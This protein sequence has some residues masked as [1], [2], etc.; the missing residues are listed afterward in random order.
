MH[1]VQA[2]P[3][4]QRRIEHSRLY[5]TQGD[6]TSFFRL[7][8]GRNLA[9]EIMTSD[10]DLRQGKP[11]LLALAGDR[12]LQP[13]LLDVACMQ[14][15]ARQQLLTVLQGNQLKIGYGLQE[16][17]VHLQQ[18]GLSVDGPFF[19]LRL[20][21]Q[22]LKAGISNK[23]P[24]LTTLIETLLGY[25]VDE[26][27]LNL[28]WEGRLY[29]GHLYAI[30]QKTKALMPLYAK[31]YKLLKNSRLLEAAELEFA[32]LPAVIE[33]SATGMPVNIEGLRSVQDQ[34]LN[35]A[36]DC[37]ERLKSWLPETVNLNS[38]QQVKAA[39]AEQGIDIPSVSKEDLM[40]LRGHPELV[41]SLLGYRKATSNESVYVRKCLEVV[42]PQTSR[43]YARWNQLGAMTG[44]F[45]CSAPPLQ[46]VP[47]N[48]GIRACFVQELG[49]VFVI[50]DLSQI[51]LRIAAELSGDSVMIAAFQN[52][53][54]LHTLTASLVTGKSIQD[55]T[56]DERQSA[57]ALNF[58][59]L[60]GMGTEGLQK[61][62]RVKYGVEMTA[63]EAVRFRESFFDAYQELAEWVDAQSSFSGRETRTLSGR[64]RRWN[65]E[66]VAATEL[67]NA[68]IQGTAA[69]ILKKALA[70]LPG[71]LSLYSAKIL[72]CIHDEI[73]LEVNKEQARE[74]AEILEVIMTEAGDYFLSHVPT[75]ADV[76]IAERWG[77]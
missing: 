46:G 62:A 35:Q 50:G 66:S 61:Y 28:P 63:A 36:R 54:D 72:A 30:H 23:P 77:K 8:A 44:R 34:L 65:T 57:K 4:T 27:D 18:A 64:R 73:I 52:D 10:S 17:G 3:L 42:D 25:E 21:A 47:K 32:C 74:V 24:E 49:K 20:A 41:S 59:L 40:S 75:V 67:I 43:V 58:G 29:Q 9:V 6:G 12:H 14:E 68:P 1:N 26:C 5:T 16:I 38:P 70:L 31:M 39:L 45:S 13:L 7:L 37:R 55:V 22:L 56:A 33:M 53:E 48:A 69:D 60:F 11:L 71:A 15:E 2:T 19:D 76:R 51:E